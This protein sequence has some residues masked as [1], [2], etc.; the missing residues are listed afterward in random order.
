MA[1][2][3]DTVPVPILSDSFKYFTGSIEFVTR[4]LAHGADILWTFVNSWFLPGFTGIGPND[5]CGPSLSYVLNT[6]MCRQ[7][8]KVQQDLFC[9]MNGSWL[10]V[11]KFKAGRKYTGKI[12]MCL[13]PF[14]KSPKHKKQQ[15]SEHAHKLPS[16]ELI[17]ITLISSNCLGDWRP[18]GINFLSLHG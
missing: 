3:L 18:V 12:I 6:D 9:A 16:D 13:F 5:P 15:E 1:E 14:S 4:W 10:E 2:V 7:A 8:R 17:K 11:S